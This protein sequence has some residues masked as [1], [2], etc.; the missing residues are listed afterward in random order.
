[1][2]GRRHQA[3]RNTDSRGW[4]NGL[5]ATST[6][7]SASV[8]PKRQVASSDRHLRWAYRIAVALAVAPI[9]VSAIRNGLA[10][11]QPTLDAG[12]TAIRV[13]DVFSAHPPLVGLAAQTSFASSAQYSYLGALQFY[14]LALPVR[15]LGVTWGL[16]AGMAAINMTVAVAAL[17]FV[18]RR[19]GMR[20]AMVAAGILASL[21]W[22][23]GSQIIIDP[24]PVVMGIVPLFAFLVAA[25][26]V[27]DGDTPALGLLAFL[28]SYLVQGHPAF[29]IVVPIVSAFAILVWIVRSLNLRRKDHDVFHAQ[30]RRGRWVVAGCLVFTILAW[31][32]PLVEQFRS[33]GGNLGHAFQAATSGQVQSLQRGAVHPTVS[34]AFGMIVSLTAVPPA[35][36]PPSFAHPP[37]DFRGGG[38]PFF[39]GLMCGLALGAV[40]FLLAVRARRRGDSTIPAAVGI[41]IVAWFAY[42]IT[43]LRNPDAYGFRARYFYGLWPLAAYVWMI[44]ALGI[45]RELRAAKPKLA[46]VAP[47]TTAALVATVILLAALAV[48]Y[49]DNGEVPGKPLV[50]PSADIRRFVAQ[51]AK[52]SGPILVQV[53]FGTSRLWPA[54]MLGLQDAGVPI[55]VSGVTLV[56]QFGHQRDIAT[57]PD[58]VSSYVLRQAGMVAPPGSRRLAAFP[59]RTRLLSPARYGRDTERLRAWAETHPVPEINPELIASKGMLSILH[60]GLRS[61]KADGITGARLLDSPGFVGLLLTSQPFVREPIFDVPGMSADELANWATD[62]AANLGPTVL[63]EAPP[64]P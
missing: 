63:Y 41:G 17:V 60:G 22:S 43:A 46:S 25:W 4:H 10:D 12:I 19:V 29:V 44:V 34:G 20:G 13:R 62:R 64:V 53:D 56:Q 3:G 38:T 9:G 40:S 49:G 27:T 45:G 42:L 33:G 51:H 6:D 1:M 11:W 7:P 32:P 52:G 35:W 24:T 31:L 18:R 48:P 36:L 54:V 23:L 57:H 61:L 55:R 15:L 14:L 37:F 39:I 8:D 50:Q 26:S 5:V 21:L 30:W 2:I 47:R 16:L 28:A 58:A 59:T